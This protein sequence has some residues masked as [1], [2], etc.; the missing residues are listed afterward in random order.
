MSNRVQEQIEQWI[1][2]ETCVV[3]VRVPAYRVDVMTDDDSHV[4]DEEPEH[5]FTPET[6]AHLERVQALADAGDIDALMPLGDVFV[7]RVS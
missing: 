7:R 3:R 4:G 6:V 2:A 1:H 5:A